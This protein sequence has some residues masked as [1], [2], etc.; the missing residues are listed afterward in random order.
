MRPVWLFACL[1]LSGCGGPTPPPVTSDSAESSPDPSVDS[2]KPPKSQAASSSQREEASFAAWSALASGTLEATDEQPSPRV[3]PPRSSPPLNSTGAN[4]G[5]G[6]AVS[7]TATPTTTPSAIVT[8][9]PSPQP[10]ATPTATATP[11]ASATTAVTP[12][13]SPSP[14]LT[15]TPTPTPTSSATPIA[16]NPVVSV[17]PVPDPGPL[18]VRG[19]IVFN[20]GPPPAPITLAVVRSTD[21]Q[22]RNVTTDDQGYFYASNLEPGTYL[23]YYYNDTQRDRIGYWRSRTLSVDESKGAGF[24]QV[25]FAQQGLVNQPAM[26]ARISLPARFEWVPPSQQVA[27]YR[28]RLHSTGGRTFRLIHQSG[29]FPGDSTEYTWDGSGVSEPLNSTNRYFWGLVWDAGAVGEGGN[30]YQSVYFNLP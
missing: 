17:V 2:L 23:A 30:L 28:F 15:P 7:A 4:S 10:S 25:D 12:S 9:S 22:Q 27:S 18:A 21:W 26:D 20:G 29:S 6:S 13:L 16:S 5:S 24:P 19:R 3:L 11:Q 14:S 1:F 8:A